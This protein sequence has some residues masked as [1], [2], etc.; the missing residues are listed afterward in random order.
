MKKW[1]ITDP[2]PPTLNACLWAWGKIINV[3]TG[4]MRRGMKRAEEIVWGW[5][6]GGRMLI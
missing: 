6:F 3:E 4:P 1:K 5:L 2:L